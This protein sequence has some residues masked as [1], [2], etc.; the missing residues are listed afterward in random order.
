[1]TNRQSFRDH[2]RAIPSLVGTP[3][4][5]DPSQHPST[6]QELFLDWFRFAER[7]NIQEP[8]AMTV[9]TVGADGVPDSR[10][11]VLKDLTA[12]GAWCFAGRTDSTK[13]RELRENPAAAMLFYWRE[14][15]RSVRIRGRILQGSTGEARGDFIARHTG[16]RAVALSGQQGA[17]LAEAATLAHDVDVA[18]KRLAA[19]AEL[20]PEEW[21]VW[22]L[23]ATEVEFWQGSNSRLHTRLR[24]QRG[25]S[26]WNASLLRP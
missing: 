4:A 11:L 9:S 17:P 13:G 3:P 1:M 18:T 6:P 21:R 7:A 25:P 12:E 5:F 8:H 22:K 20:V 2:L 24:Y 10:M 19:D 15:V 23:E 26:G 14:Q 16:A